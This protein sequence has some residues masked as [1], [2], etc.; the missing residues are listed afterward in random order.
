[1]LPSMDPNWAVNTPYKSRQQS[2]GLSLSQQQSSGL[3]LTQ[4]Q[5]PSSILRPYGTSS[6]KNSA[7]NALDGIYAD[8]AYKV[9]TSQHL[10]SVLERQDIDYILSPHIAFCRACISSYL[11]LD[12]SFL[13]QSIV[14][15]H[16]VYP[17]LS[18]YDFIFLAHS[19]R[20]ISTYWHCA[21]RQKKVL[22]VKLLAASVTRQRII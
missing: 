12:I 14:L 11:M 3:S 1:M 21:L 13:T 18:L 5:A 15:S 22:A 8:I 6:S 7:R 2:T 19:P 4:P 20:W 16:F 9:E 17:C 10:F